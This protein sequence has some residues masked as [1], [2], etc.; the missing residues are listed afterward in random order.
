MNKK[1]LRA[2]LED[3]LRRDF[4]HLAKRNRDKYI[5]MK[6]ESDKYWI[7][8]GKD[9]RLEVS[10]NELAA[11]RELIPDQIHAIFIGFDN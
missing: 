10:D 4:L 5:F 3:E 1:L 8:T 11:L 2:V 9:Y 6:I 7:T